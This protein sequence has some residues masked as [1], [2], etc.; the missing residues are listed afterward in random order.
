M[1]SILATVELSVVAFAALHIPSPC[2]SQIAPS[3]V[4]QIAS[5]QEKYRHGSIYINSGTLN[6]FRSHLHNGL[7]RQ[8]LDSM[9]PPI[10]MACKVLQLYLD[11]RYLEMLRPG[12]GISILI[13]DFRS[14]RAFSKS[15]VDA[16]G[17]VAELE[18][19]KTEVLAVAELVD[20]L[21]YGT[22]TF[23]DLALKIETE[24]KSI[25]EAW[26]KATSSKANPYA[27]ADSVAQYLKSL[28]EAA[29]KDPELVEKIKLVD[30]QTYAQVS[31][32]IENTNQIETASVKSG[33]VAG[34]NKWNIWKLNE[35]GFVLS[36]SKSSA[37]VLIDQAASAK[38]LIR[39][40][41]EQATTTAK[42]LQPSYWAN[43]PK[44]S[45]GIFIPS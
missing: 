39:L 6:S 41:P 30:P 35:D 23:R 3:S 25:I 8:A 43:M 14:G 45:R 12:W 18:W 38:D 7:K 31:T 21:L 36:G 34:G 10:P 24:P 33:A 11:S 27:T 37:S 15:E 28:K 19:T 9:I 1:K 32:F 40:T 42:E 2:F 13:V 5:L 16:T 26:Q 17:S 4:F 20:K 44:R 29:D 22:G